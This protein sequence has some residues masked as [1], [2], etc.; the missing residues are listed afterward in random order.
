[1]SGRTAPTMPTSHGTQRRR[2]GKGKKKRPQNVKAAVG[3][4]QQPP[5]PPQPAAPPRASRLVLCIRAVE[6][7]GLVVAAL[8][9]FVSVGQFLG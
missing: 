3:R 8:G 7:V 5:A 9:F 6:T 4:P 2:R 1:M